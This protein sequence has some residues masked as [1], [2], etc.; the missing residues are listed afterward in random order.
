MIMRWS[1]RRRR[2]KERKIVI[3]MAIMRPSRKRRSRKVVILTMMV[4]MTMMMPDTAMGSPDY[5]IIHKSIHHLHV[6]S[7]FT[8]VHKIPMIICMT[9]VTKNCS[10]AKQKSQFSHTLRKK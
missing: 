1:R 9:L 6:F 8:R 2:R 5:D 10:S 3:L 7:T 4:I